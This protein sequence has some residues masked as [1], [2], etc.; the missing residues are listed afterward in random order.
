MN[1]AIFASGA[2]SNAAN[3]IQYFGDKNN[4]NIAL[5]VCNVPTAGVIAIAENHHIPVLLIEKDRFFKGDGYLS[6]LQEYKIDFIV[7]AGFL[8]KVPVN[9]IQAYPN[10]IVNIHP[11]LLPQYGG[12]G[13]YGAN[14]HNAI[15]A[16]KEKETGI[17]IHIVDEIYDN[18]KILFQEKCA[19][20]VDD[21]ADTVAQKVHALEYAYFPQQVE[22]WI[23][24]FNS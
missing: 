7:L 9:L 17:T 20:S 19:I 23:E 13:M 12:K 16:N 6:I 21:T 10:R 3:L 18:G 1:I 11:A 24:S 15:I 5:I 8:W 22:K 2:G 14:V 4:F